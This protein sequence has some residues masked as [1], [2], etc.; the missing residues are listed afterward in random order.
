MYNVLGNGVSDVIVPVRTSATVGLKYLR[1]LIR[2]R[3]A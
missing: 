3:R 2:Q 1:S